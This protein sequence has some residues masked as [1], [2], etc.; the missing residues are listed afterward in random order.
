M[1]GRWS[2]VEDL[3]SSRATDPGPPFAISRR[4]GDLDAHGRDEN[5]SGIVR[6]VGVVFARS[7]DDVTSTLRHARETGTPVIPWGA[8]TSA[9]GQVVPRGDEL[10]LDVSGMNRILR[11]SIDD[12]T[13]TVEPGVTPGCS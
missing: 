3:R 4:Q 13:V 8:G 1:L 7:T 5:S 10:V 12:M 2:Q 6:P 11:H 9:D